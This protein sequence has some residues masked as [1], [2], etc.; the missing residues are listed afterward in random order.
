MAVRISTGSL[1]IDQIIIGTPYFSKKLKNTY[2]KKQ[3]TIGQ[4][5]QFYCVYLK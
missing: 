3:C 1:W 5:N 2:I 4:K